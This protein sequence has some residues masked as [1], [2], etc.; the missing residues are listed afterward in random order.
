LFLEV[1]LA[2]MKLYK[3]KDQESYIKLLLLF[4]MELKKYN[5]IFDNENY[6]LS[7]IVSRDEFSSSA[8][9][10]VTMSITKKPLWIIFIYDPRIL[11]RI[12]ESY[13]NYFTVKDVTLVRPFNFG[14]SNKIS[15]ATNPNL[16]IEERVLFEFFRNSS[17][18]MN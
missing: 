7:Y 11:K 9:I 10:R 13:C 16:P 1:I 18:W 12:L 2:N 14:G 5:K 4:E 8:E 6:S 17:K 15:T 3:R